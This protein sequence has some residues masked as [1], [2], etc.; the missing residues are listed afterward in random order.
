MSGARFDAPKRRAS[1][2]AWPR[3]PPRPRPLGLAILALLV[4]ALLPP[5]ALLPAAGAVLLGADV[6]QRVLLTGVG[7]HRMS[8]AAMALGSVVI[9][10]AV[11]LTIV[12]LAGA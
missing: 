10:V 6:R 7:A 8:A 11:A 4:V 1:P 5:L 2:S 3:C 12:G 9:A